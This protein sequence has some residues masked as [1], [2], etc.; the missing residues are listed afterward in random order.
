MEIYV[1]LLYLIVE[2]EKSSISVS[3]EMSP[4]LAVYSR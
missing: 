1:W 2:G 3:L 4:T